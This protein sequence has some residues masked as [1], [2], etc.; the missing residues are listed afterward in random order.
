LKAIILAKECQIK[1]V[2]NYSKH[3]DPNSKLSHPFVERQ[4]SLEIFSFCFQIHELAFICA[5]NI[6]VT[7]SFSS[8]RYQREPD[9]GRKQKTS[10]VLLK[11]PY[12]G[13]AFSPYTIF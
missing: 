6:S 3:F 7:I 10:N 2:D 13:S 8:L 1:P 4:S 9:M 5:Q 11:I 12:N